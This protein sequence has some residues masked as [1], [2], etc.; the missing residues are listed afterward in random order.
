MSWNSPTNVDEMR[1]S[2]HALFVWRARRCDLAAER[3]WVLSAYSVR[4]E[5]GKA[6][7]DGH[8]LSD[9]VVTGAEAFRDHYM[10]AEDRT[11]ARTPHPSTVVYYIRDTRSGRAVLALQA[12]GTVLDELETVRPDLRPTTVTALRDA[13]AIAAD[14]L[15]ASVK[16]NGWG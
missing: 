16:R 11:T 2:T 1:S 7:A 10:T 5:L 13:M 9:H 12:D 4:A 3:V 6:A 14:N 15:R 8:A